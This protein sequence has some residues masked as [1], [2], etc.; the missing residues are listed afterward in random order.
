MTDYAHVPRPRRLECRQFPA[1]R[2]RWLRRWP[3]QYLEHRDLSYTASRRSV[4]PELPR[5]FT[6]PCETLSFGPATQ[7]NAQNNAFV[8]GVCGRA[9]ASD[10]A[11]TPNV[12]LRGEYEYIH[13]APVDGISS[14][15]QPPASAPASSSELQSCSCRNTRRGACIVP[16]DG[17][18]H[19]LIPAAGHPS[20]TRGDYLE[21]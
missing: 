15:C 10:I 3:G 20:P 7:S 2:F 16:L 8:Y 12:F 14:R 1:L 19:S 5:D 9:S 4:I 11:L 6:P 21:G 17:G 13:F 18:F